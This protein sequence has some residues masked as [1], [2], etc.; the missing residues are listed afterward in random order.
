MSTATASAVPT[1]AIEVHP[2]IDELRKSIDEI[3]LGVMTSGYS[4]ADAI[5]EGAS[6]TDQ[7]VGGWSDTDGSVCA[8]SGAY[9]AAKARGLV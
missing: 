1:A 6:V 8:L 9:I 3:G 4:L 5:R 7:K 2:G